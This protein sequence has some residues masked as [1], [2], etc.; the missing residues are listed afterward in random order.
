VNGDGRMGPRCQLRCGCGN[1]PRSRTQ[2]LP[3]VGGL[4]GSVPVGIG[5]VALFLSSVAAKHVLDAAQGLSGQAQPLSVISDTGA[6]SGLPAVI[7]GARHRLILVG[8]RGLRIRSLP[9]GVTDRRKGPMGRASCRLKCSVFVG[10]ERGQ[11]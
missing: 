6:A 3:A 11:C 8:L 9:V 7:V 5:Y 2:A 4:A 10:R 1:A